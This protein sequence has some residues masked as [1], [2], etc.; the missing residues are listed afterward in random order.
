MKTYMT[1][2]DVL[3][4]IA[5]GE[6]SKGL[7][8]SVNPNYAKRFN[9]L[10]TALEKLLDEVRESFPDANYYSP[11]DGMALLLGSSHADEYGEPPQKEL[12][13]VFSSALCGKLSG[14]D[15]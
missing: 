7:L 15:W 13:A 1:E 14:G 8:D 4:A 6:T 3:E 10:N 2:E 9:R 5:E 11:N 12:E